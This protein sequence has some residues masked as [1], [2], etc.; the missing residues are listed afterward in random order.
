M[1][2]AFDAQSHESLIL[3]V[4]RQR[5]RRAFT[6]LFDHFAPRVKAFLQ[7]GG[8]ASAAAEDMMQEVLLTVWNKASQFD[9]ARA[10]VQAWIFGIAR[11]LKIDTLRR[12]RIPLPDLDPM[13]PEPEP[14][15]D[16]L[17]AARQSSQSVRQAIADL[18]AEQIEVL[19]L[20]YYEEMSHGEIEETLGLP[21]GTIKSRLRLAMAK[22]RQVLKEA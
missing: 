5:D 1:T 9:P 16:A 4:A 15:S 14:L 7:R 19:K 18:P 13:A 21:L 2:D 10:S 11:N 3:A 22:L 12:S 8:T 17:V 20:A 6:E